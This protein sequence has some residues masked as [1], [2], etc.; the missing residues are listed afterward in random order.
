M[1][2][3]FP[4]PQDYFNQILSGINQVIKTH[5]N[6]M[7]SKFETQFSSM[8]GEV[9]R[10]DA[11]I[12]QLQLKLRAI[13]QKSTVAALT[14]RRLKREKLSQLSVDD[15][16][17]G[18]QDNSSSGSSAELLFMV[19]ELEPLFNNGITPR[20]PLSPSPLARRLARHGVYLVSTRSGRTAQCLTRSESAPCCLRERTEL[21][22]QLLQWAGYTDHTA[23]PEPS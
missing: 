13:E 12:A 1:L 18:E 3:G 22:E 11:I 2:Q 5:M 10:R 4:E 8:A 17:P 20:A 21:P 6:E 19:S 14:T 9:R 7:H 16:E 15:D 23:R